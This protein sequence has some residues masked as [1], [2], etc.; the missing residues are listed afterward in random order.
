LPPRYVQLLY[1]ANTAAIIAAPAPNISTFSPAAAFADW[2]AAAELP[3]E[4]AAE[5][6][7]PTALEAEAA[8]DAVAL[9]LALAAATQISALTEAALA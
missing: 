3:A 7:E 9:P 6:A 4:A 1:K 5:V 8:P 2:V